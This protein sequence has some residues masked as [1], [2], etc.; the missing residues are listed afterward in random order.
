MLHEFMELLTANSPIHVLPEIVAILAA[1]AIIAYIS[2]RLGQVPIVGFLLAGVLIGPNALGLVNDQELIEVVAEIG[3]ILLLF[4]IGIEFSLEKLARIKRLIFVG[5][6]LQVALTIALTVVVLLAFNVNWRVGV[7]TG[8]LIALSST[9]IILK[10][11]ADR[12]ET[13][14][15]S[16]QIALGILIFQDLAVI[17]MVLLLP[18]LAGT[19]GSILNIFLEL[20]KAAIIIALVLVFARRVMPPILET[21]AQTCSQ[22]IFL[23]SVIAICFGTAWLTSLA[24]VSLSLGAF[25]AGLVVSESQFSE[26][27]F[28]EIMP[29]QIL[30]SAAFFVSVGLLL[31]LGF[32]VA[33]PL[34]V[35]G[36]LVGIVLVKLLATGI[37][38]MLLGY[39]LPTILLSGFMLVQVG[40]FAFVL[41]RE[42]RALDL[43]PAGLAET[44]GQTFIAASVILMVLTPFLA[45]AG[46]WMQ[47]R[48]E[49]RTT[50]T[51]AQKAQAQEATEH[52]G[53]LQNH[54]IVAGYGSAGQQL[55]R[56]L[57][58]SGIPFV[59]ITLN[60]VF[61]AAADAEGLPVLRGDDT[62]LHTL[63][64]V[65]IRRAKLL[66]VADDN[67][68]DARRVVAV[69][70]TANPTLTIIV[71]TRYI[72][73][74]EPL[75]EAGADIVI[76]EELESMVQLFVQVLD[77]Y[78]VDEEEIET[79]VHSL[80]AHGYAA[81]LEP[82]ERPSVVCED[83]DDDCMHL[84]KVTIR[85]GAPAARQSLDLPALQGEYGL[86][87]QGIQR[88][89]EVITD[90]PTTLELQP[91]DRL[92]LLGSAEQF[93]R[94]GDLFRVSIITDG[95]GMPVVSQAPQQQ[96]QAGTCTHTNFIQLVSSD[97]QGCE[98]CLKL[99]DTW[100]HLRMC[101]TCGH[102]GC[103]DSSKNKHA[104]RHFQ[105][106]GHPIIQSFEPG[107]DWRWCYID[108][109]YV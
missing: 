20:G 60:P 101:L 77:S 22:E 79:H 61:A 92:L 62:R 99:G 17:V 4:T 31:D 67:P 105:E 48:L 26:H 39:S 35:L 33:N 8:S 55:V 109:T 40:E 73:E 24:G 57:R 84:R 53:H 68:A 65:N 43:F 1:G 69:A 23:L 107:E 34:L 52:F 87:V 12:S 18:M 85:A 104:T 36:V 7:F 66:V 14:S 16:G 71:R 28:G 6:G 70:R 32:V 74:V 106:T 94:S 25:L 72:V 89:G 86:R 46:Y 80:R 93:V 3:I 78:R 81:L 27:A 75:V 13:N 42:A 91:G 9:A 41:E 97:A 44:G 108:K 83:L 19:G 2:Q 90:L 59:I 29:L 10:L 51:L 95:A 37:G 64:L 102:V 100:V 98:E 54:V 5:G 47:A 58:G 76:P 96:A 45:Q 38:V 50:A 49:R 15:E 11:L 30:F 103:C 21:V 88:N 63:E 82:S 56:V